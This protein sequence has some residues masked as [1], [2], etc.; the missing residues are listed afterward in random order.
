VR[1]LADIL[2]V[3][4]KLYNDL[5]DFSH[6]APYYE[7]SLDLA[8][9]VDDPVIIARNLNN[10][11]LIEHAQ[12]HY[13]LAETLFTEALTL[14]RALDLALAVNVVMMN[15]ANV[16]N[17]LG[18]LERALALYWEALELTRQS[19]HRNQIVGLLLN[20]A[21]AYTYYYRDF[22]QAEPLFME[23]LNM[24]IEIGALRLE[25]QVRLG[26]ANM[27]RLRGQFPQ[28]EQ[29]IQEGLALAD[30][31]A[32]GETRM[33]AFCMRGELFLDMNRVPEAESSLEIALS[34]AENLV[35][36]DTT[37]A[38]I[39]FIQAR[40]L[41][42]QAQPAQ[43]CRLAQKSLQLYEKMGPPARVDTVRRWLENL[44]Q[45]R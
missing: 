25:S 44:P 16:Y 7:Q 20:L 12:G 28:A 36:Q 18:D 14:F 1:E 29:Q 13:S 40:T 4:G 30:R 17:A 37:I 26:Y 34:I 22:A 45:T 2:C 9:Q 10:I 6:A 19:N 5:G 21:L 24:A 35:Y 31:M 32:D 38:E 27:L 23:A 43:A 39:L 33:K 8:R 15:L 42:A 3:L 11:G 41:L